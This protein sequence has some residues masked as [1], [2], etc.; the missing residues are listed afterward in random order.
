MT[1]LKNKMDALTHASLAVEEHMRQERHSTNDAA[2]S[3]TSAATIA[4]AIKAGKRG[5]ALIFDD[6]GKVSEVVSFQPGDPSVEIG[7]TRRET[8]NAWQANYE[9]IAGEHFEKRVAKS[10][11][12]SE[13][14]KGKVEPQISADAA[15]QAAKRAEQDAIDAKREK[16]ARDTARAKSDYQEGVARTEKFAAAVKAHEAGRSA[17]R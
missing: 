11:E 8:A 17:G 6:D 13:R 14:T 10:H 7:M 4:T 9:Q 12:Q 5:V 2:F 16:Q 15:L 1:T 3:A